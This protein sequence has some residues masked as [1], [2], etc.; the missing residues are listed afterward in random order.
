MDVQ[1]V[2]L[3]RGESGVSIP[4]RPRGSV[5]C[6]YLKSLSTKDLTGMFFEPPCQLH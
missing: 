5:D 4:S 6:L 1:Q 3:G 2:D